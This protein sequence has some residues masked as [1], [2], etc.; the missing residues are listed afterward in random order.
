MII[1]ET[2]GGYLFLISFFQFMPFIILAIIIEIP[3]FYIISKFT[4]YNFFETH[5]AYFIRSTTEFVYNISL[6]LAGIKCVKNISVS[7]TSPEWPS[8]V[9]HTCSCTHMHRCWTS[10]P[11]V[12]LTSH[13][14]SLRNLVH[15]K[16][17]SIWYSNLRIFDE[18]L[19]LHFYRPHQ[20]RRSHSK[21]QHWLQKPS[22]YTSLKLT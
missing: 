7:L 18:L 12:S 13:R 10:W 8:Q 17:V 2:V 6:H 14:A 9:H 4:K 5:P 16:K 11:W 19:S 15:R 1:S 21:T 3:L 22:E 20:P